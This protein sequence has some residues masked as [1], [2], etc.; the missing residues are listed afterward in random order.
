M[1]G[2]SEGWSNYITGIFYI[3]FYIEF[4][5]VFKQVSYLLI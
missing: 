2:F 5:K 4:V 1:V 3:V